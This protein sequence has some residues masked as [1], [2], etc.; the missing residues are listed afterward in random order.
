MV[1]NQLRTGVSLDGSIVRNGVV[2]IRQGYIED[3][4]AILER[5]CNTRE[6]TCTVYEIRC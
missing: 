3:L 6:S 4:S 5:V 2:R 1:I